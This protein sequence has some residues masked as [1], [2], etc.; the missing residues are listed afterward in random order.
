[1]QARW[2]ILMKTGLYKAKILFKSIA[3]N[4]NE[5][6]YALYRLLKSN[7]NVT[8]GNEGRD[9]PPPFGYCN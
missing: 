3:F 7:K 4:N 1:M 6:N 2:S 8:A 5:Y 9:V